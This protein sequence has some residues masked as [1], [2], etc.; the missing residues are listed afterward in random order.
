MQKSQPTHNT[1]KQNYPGSVAL[2]Q[3]SA[4]KRDGLILQCSRANRWLEKSPA[5]LQRSSV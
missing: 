2:L 3:C 5:E 4:R 1:A